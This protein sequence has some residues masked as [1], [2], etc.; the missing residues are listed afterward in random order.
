[1]SKVLV[2]VGMHRSGTSLLAHYV[3]E[4]GLFIGSDLL[5]KHPSNPAGH[6]EDREFLSLHNELLA[7]HAMD[8]KITSKIPWVI[9]G[10][11][12]KRAETLISQRNK[13]ESWGWKDPR[14]CLF[15]DFWN[16]MLPQTTVYLVCYRNYSQVIKSLLVRDIVRYRRVTNRLERI[17]NPRFNT[18]QISQYAEENLKMWIHYNSEILQLLESKK[19]QCILM[20]FDEMIQGNFSRLDQLQKR[21]YSLKTPDGFQSIETKSRHTLNIRFKLDPGIIATADRL[22]SRF[23]ELLAD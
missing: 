16:A 19:P 17:L 23:R 9:D 11:F 5:G 15:L 13:Y 6:F 2:I 10:T 4:C 14:T 18:K 20:P 1:M 21:G 7:A 8:H 3:Q 12:Y 22:A